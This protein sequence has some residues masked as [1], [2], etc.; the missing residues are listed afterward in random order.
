MAGIDFSRIEDEAFVIRLEGPPHLISAETLSEALLG[1][2]AS[3]KEINR[4]IN[5]EHRLDVLV[6]GVSP[7]SV[8]ISVTLH[9][10]VL[11]SLANSLVVTSVA[12]PIIA[13]VL[14]AYIYDKLKGDPKLTTVEIQAEGL[15][16]ATPDATIH[17]SK[18]AL[19]WSEK[20]R[21]NPKVAKGIRRV[22]MAAKKDEAVESIGI[23]P[24]GAEPSVVTVPR[25]QFRPIAERLSQPESLSLT[26]EDSVE[27]LSPGYRK[28]EVRA[29]LIVIKAVF[30]RSHRKWQFS[31]G[32]FPISA[33]ISDQMFFDSLERRD[34]ALRQGDALDALL[35]VWQRVLPDSGAWEN[36][37]YEVTKVYAVKRG[38]TQKTMRFATIDKPSKSKLNP[39]LNVP[40]HARKSR[41]RRESRAK[42]GHS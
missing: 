7:G 33:A 27:M 18:D 2:S 30:M 1:F 20:V 29:R 32:G 17:I 41:D 26:A 38:E 4:V 9:Q 31:W 36:V 35:T 40:T 37:E 3:L 8:L 11:A 34:V 25:E 15:V 39:K 16:I 10:D 28:R 42:N 22:L 14:G 21:D 19:A 24:N 23:G 13:Q 12:L 6:R 5:P